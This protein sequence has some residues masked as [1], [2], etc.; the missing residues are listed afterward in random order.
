MRFAVAKGE[1]AATLNG[2]A[3]VTFQ[4]GTTAGTIR[5]T[6]SGI[7]QGFA[8]DPTV[9]LAIPPAQIAVDRVVATRLP[10][11]LRLDVIGFDNTYGLGAMLFRFFDA[12]GQLLTPPIPVDFTAVFRDY[13]GSALSGSAFRASIQFPVTGDS[14]GIAAMEAEMT[15]PAGTVQIGRLVF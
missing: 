7:P 8:A 15:N 1:T 2:L 11:A 6:F 3:S 4:T 12:G 9:T 5:F 10:L 13:F 14:I